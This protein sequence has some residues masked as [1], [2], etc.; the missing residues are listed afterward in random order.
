[1]RGTL[2]SDKQRGCIEIFRAG[3]VEDLHLLTA[4]HA[5]H[6][7]KPLR[8]HGPMGIESFVRGRKE[9]RGGRRRDRRV[10]GMAEEGF[11]LITGKV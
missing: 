2:T 7:T 1:M 3:W 9:A 4:E 8:G 6:T 5:Q 11:R 10:T